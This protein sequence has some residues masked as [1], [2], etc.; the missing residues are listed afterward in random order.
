MFHEYFVGRPYP[1]TPGWHDSMHSSHVLYTWLF[2]E[3]ASRKLQMFFILSLS[4]HTLSHSSLTI[5]NP[6]KYKEI[7]LNKITIKFGMELKPTQNSCKSQLYRIEESNISTLWGL[8]SVKK[9]SL[10]A[11]SSD[12]WHG[13]FFCHIELKSLR[14]KLHRR[15]RRIWRRR[16]KKKI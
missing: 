15:R 4:L 3:L 5:K 14:L 12:C 16:K 13:V 10:K 2:R 11:S 7:W 6:H 9:L 8:S 1:W